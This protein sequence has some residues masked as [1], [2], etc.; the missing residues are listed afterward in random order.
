MSNMY[1]FDDPT[2][3]LAEYQASTPMAPMHGI[4]NK[5]TAPDNQWINQNISYTSANHR[6]LYIFTCRLLRFDLL[7]RLFIF[8]LVF[9]VEETRYRCIIL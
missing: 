4:Y 9:S 2:V 6:A 5:P 8:V 7:I 1:L 3:P